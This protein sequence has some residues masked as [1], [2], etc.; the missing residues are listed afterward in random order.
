MIC[1]IGEVV[2][3]MMDSVEESLA[4]VYDLSK[5]TEKELLYL[6][7]CLVAGST[8]NVC[9]EEETK[10]ELQKIMEK[11]QNKKDDNRCLRR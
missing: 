6:K 1:T 7:G 9:I 2:D 3:S 11:L 8:G 4:K 10:T 5:I